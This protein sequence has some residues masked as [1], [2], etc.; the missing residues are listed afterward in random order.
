MAEEY[1]YIVFSEACIIYENFWVYL[2]KL[3]YCAEQI[4]VDKIIHHTWHNDLPIYQSVLL[5]YQN[6]AKKYS[7]H[8]MLYKSSTYFLEYVVYFQEKTIYQICW[9]QQSWL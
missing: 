9:F 1:N 5:C 8:L 4:S 3:T 2:K 7:C 6:K